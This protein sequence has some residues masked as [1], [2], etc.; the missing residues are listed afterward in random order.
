MSE[1]HRSKILVV[2]DDVLNVRLIEAQLMT[3][4]TIEAAYSGE[5]ALDLIDSDKPDLVILDVMMP[6]MSGYDVCRRIKSSKDTC[7]IPV[8]IVTALSSRNDRMEGIM[9]GADEFL[10]K[11]FDRFEVLTRVRT[12]LKSKQLY[13][14]LI[15]EGD[16]TK[17]YLDIAGCMIVAFDIDLTVTIAN[18][19]CNEVLG[20]AEGELIGS[21]W[22]EKA[23]PAD[24]RGENESL[25][26]NI[27]KGDVSPVECFESNVLTKTGQKKLISWRNS[28]VKDS[29]GKITTI[30]SSGS[31]ITEQRHSEQKIKV[32]EEKFRALF[33]NAVDSIMI[34]DMDY[35]ILEVNPSL[36]DL[37]LYRK[38]EML[39][40][41]RSDFIAPEYLHKCKEYLVS[42]L[43]KGHSVFE[44]ECLKK[45]GSRVPVE[46]SIKVI[47]YEGKP[48]ILSNVRDITERKQSERTL[49]ESE[50]KFRMLA[51]NAN[52]VIWTMDKNGKFLYVSP[53]VIKLR[54]Y[55]PEEVMNQ[56]FP[57][58][59]SQDSILKIRSA[60]GAFFSDVQYA[61]IANRT[62]IMELEQFHKQGYTVWTEALATPLFDKNGNFKFFQGVTRDISERKKSQEAIRNYVH[63]LGKANESLHSLDR[64]K[65][66]FISNLSHELK[67][68]L[69]SIKGYSELVYDEVLGP[70]TDKQKNA[71]HIV[72]DK[73]DH[74]S[75]LLDS[76]IYISI[77]RSGKVNYR[78]D[79]LRIED[80]LKKV[81][82]YFSFKATEKNIKLV[83]NF[84]N[85]LPLVK[86]DVEYIPYIFR[87]VIDNAIKFSKSEG[88]I[89]V[90]AYRD[91]GNVHVV[92]KDNGIGIPKAEFSNIFN[93]FYQ[94]DSSLTRRY[95]GSGLGL[96]VSKTI[97]EVH[98]GSIWIESEEGKG[99][100]VHVSFPSYSP[101]RT[102]TK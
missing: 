88:V 86:G 50:E 8:I 18:A 26:R 38:D 43:E 31:D 99:T 7:F 87:S 53:S 95:G 49:Q 46:M 70:L 19:K 78:F 16:R 9:A 33:E 28:Y 55:T 45:D 2:D 63:E 67:T 21:S 64:M 54:G 39:Q 22:L 89:E 41:S 14:E 27:L 61:K 48:A 24:E 77:A 76:L 23:V 74:L 34:L 62:E 11:P 102:G 13:D 97:T 10:T 40:L 35:N 65:D 92:V 66:E 56:C 91:N 96:H 59:F 69:I 1:K 42:A 44:T 75:F 4:Y 85:G 94:V 6:G 81:M 17:K 98:S 32:S 100:A 37:L 93:P 71:L 101:S 57:E 52:D 60:M 90:S 73:Y 51:E 36:C 3:E 30:L 72:L 84:E 83:R 79:P 58:I 20:Y 68:P 15:A 12:L 80:A 29:T 25:F 82:D 47:E 5:E